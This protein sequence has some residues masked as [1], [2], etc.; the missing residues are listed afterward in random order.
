MSEPQTY[1]SDE[2]ISGL[3]TLTRWD[4]NPA[5]LFVVRLEWESGFRT[6]T[7]PSLQPGDRIIAVDGEDITAW[8]DETRRKR[9]NTLP[10]Q[11]E[12][13]GVY[14]ARGMKEG[15]VLALTVL[16]RS[17]PMGWTRLEIKGTVQRRRSYRDPQ[18]SP[19]LFL[20]G[21][22]TYERDGFNDGWPEWTEKLA[23]LIDEVCADGWYRGSFVSRFASSQLEE[24]RA[25][26]DVLAQKYPGTFANAVRADFD[27]AVASALGTVYDLPPDALDF[28]RVAEE[29]ARHVGAMGREAWQRWIAA[30][31][32]DI[33]PAFPVAHPILEPAEGVV[34]KLVQLDPIPTSHWLSDLGRQVMVSGGAERGWYAV[35][36]DAQQARAML[37]AM[38]RFTRGITP[39]LTEAFAFLARVDEGAR[40]VVVGTT[41][42]WMRS[43]TP[44]A[45]IVGEPGSEAFAVDLRNVPDTPNPDVAF[46]GEADAMRP[47]T[48]PPAA[49]ASPASVVAA[50]VAALKSGD[51]STWR[52]LF[53]DWSVRRWPD[54]RPRVD[55]AMDTPRDSDF[56]DSRR[57]L[58]G[59]V[60]DARV[61][62]T[63]DIVHV[64]DAAEYPGA[65][66]IEEAMVE[67]EHIGEA[68][69]GG[70]RA[71]K[72]V[73]VVRA[74]ALQRVN[75]GPWRITS[76]QGL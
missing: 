43:V 55:Y 27:A 28:R 12:E 35:D 22:S 56:E 17:R 2:L 44:L 61:V 52:S 48:E 76:V 24:Q 18:N 16:R 71:F 65:P 26:V 42:Y 23:K 32:K 75:A 21:P 14:A 30:N 6:G 31:S 29:R 49:D 57:E 58:L 9:Q 39:R 37:R 54:G 25:R 40:L 60:A 67:L 11:Y 73:T 34:T 68:P 41:A 45:A 63:D 20:G 33:I 50:M 66:L 5:H 7:E 15:D 19:T 4:A 38:R 10:G 13:S 53:A 59:K 1:Y 46:E 3:S 72:D 36:A 69:T 51:V 62:W 70:Y 47:T 8:D 64:T 74:W